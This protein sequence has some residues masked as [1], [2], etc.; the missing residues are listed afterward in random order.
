MKDND[1]IELLVPSIDQLFSMCCLQYRYMLQTKMKM[2]N[3]NGKEVMRQML[4]LTMLLMSLYG[5][6]DLVK[7]AS[8]AVLHD[9][10]NV[11]VLILLEPGVAELP[12]GSQLVRALNVLTVKIIDRSNH[13]GPRTILD[14]K[15]KLATLDEVMV[16]EQAAYGL[17]HVIFDNLNFKIHRTQFDYTLPVLLFET[18][19]TYQHSVLDGL[20]HDEKLKLFTPELLFMNAPIN[21]KYKKAVELVACTGLRRCCPGT[22]NMPSR[23]RQVA[24]WSSDSS[25]EK[26]EYTESMLAM[27]D[28]VTVDKLKKFI[29]N[30]K[31][32]YDLERSTF[33]D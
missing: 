25:R 4:Y 8:T 20:A 21:A 13:N 6:R 11:I 5:Y 32:L 24:G 19:P 26:V 16:K 29:N 23:T 33:F 10:V 12:E 1:K 28:R 30:K 22:T 27:W 7:R 3:T 18:V 9:L 17:F 31:H 14:T 15:D 2:D